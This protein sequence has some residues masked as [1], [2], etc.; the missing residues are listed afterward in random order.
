MK[1][2]KIFDGEISELKISSLPTRPTALTSYGGRGYSSVQ[3]KAA[4]DALPL[5]IIDRFNLLIDSLEAEGEDSVASVIK[6]GLSEGQTLSGLFDAIR[7]GSVL[8]LISVG[9]TSLLGYLT[10]L[11]DDLDRALAALNLSTEGDA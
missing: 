8:S 4:F 10:A 1:A 11:R 7:D 6:T 5:F 9:D 2:T 3:M